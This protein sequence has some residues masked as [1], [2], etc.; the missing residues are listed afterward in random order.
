M[1]AEA[2][3]AVLPGHAEFLHQCHEVRVGSF[4]E[5]DEACV[6][7]H[8]AAIVGDVNGVRMPADVIVGLED[9]YVV[10]A[11]QQAG[12]Y[13]TRYAGPDYGDTHPVLL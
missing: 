7:G 2:H 12:S 1:D 5:D 8:G 13:H 4:V 3:V 9:R 11:M 6:H 10:L